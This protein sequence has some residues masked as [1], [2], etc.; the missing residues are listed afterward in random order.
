MKIRVIAS[1]KVGYCMP[2][3]EAI[4]FSGKAAGICY[5]PDTVDKL[6]SEAE[7]KTKRRANSNIALG[8]HSVFGHATYILFWRM[9]QRFWLCF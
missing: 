3:E 4:L 8:H 1:T 2:K 6:F 7:E 9:L 5:L